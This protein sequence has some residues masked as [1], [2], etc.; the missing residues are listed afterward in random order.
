MGLYFLD[1]R[2]LLTTPSDILK[3]IIY[4][5]LPCSKYTHR[6]TGVATCTVGVQTLISHSRFFFPM[7]SAWNLFE[8]CLVVWPPMLFALIDNLCLRNLLEQPHSAALKFETF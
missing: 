4:K 6:L 3:N 1:T 8:T 2:C 5:G 7:G